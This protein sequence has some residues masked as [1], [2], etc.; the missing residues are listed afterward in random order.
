MNETY[1]LSD[2]FVSTRNYIHFILLKNNTSR[3]VPIEPNVTTV[4]K[5]V[6]LVRVESRLSASGEHWTWIN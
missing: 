6:R 4:L 2:L 5:V 1:G 3:L